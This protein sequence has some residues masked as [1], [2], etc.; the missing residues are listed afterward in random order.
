MRIALLSPVGEGQLGVSLARG[1]AAAGHDVRF[2]RA[3]LLTSDGRLLP[4]IHRVGLDALVSRPLTLSAARRSGSPDVVLVI[5]GRFVRAGDVELLRQITGA[6]VVNYFPDNPLD[7]RLREPALMEALATYDLVVVW[8]RLLADQLRSIGV[9][10]A[11]VVAFGYDPE[12]YSPPPR[13]TVPRF[14]VAFVGG[15]SRHRLRWLRELAGLNVAVAGPHWRRVAWGTP[16]AG[17]VLNGRYWGRAVAR[18]YWSARVGVN[19]LDPQNLIGHNMRTWELPATATASVATR[20]D[21]HEALFGA[22]GALLV[23]RPD[24]LRAAVDRLLADARE[25]EAVG[26]AGREAVLAGTWQ[27]RARELAGEMGSLASGL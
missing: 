3:A 10:R 24:Q 2:V 21:D 18:L 17:A 4:R 20:T 9:R 16:L 1:F 5:R 26:R 25:R 6:P 19:V 27:A 11:A 8:S 12:L 14:D 22:G 7:V 23:E 13:A 15:A